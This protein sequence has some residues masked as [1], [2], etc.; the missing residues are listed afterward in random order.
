MLL[1]VYNPCIFHVWF[2]YYCIYMDSETLHLDGFRDSTFRIGVFFRILLHQNRNLMD[3]CE[4]T[5]FFFLFYLL[6][7][8]KICHYVLYS[9]NPW[10]V[11]VFRDGQLAFYIWVCWPH[12]IHLQQLCHIFCHIR[13]NS[14]LPWDWESSHIMC[15]QTLLF[16][17]APY[18]YKIKLQTVDDLSNANVNNVMCVQVSACKNGFPRYQKLLQEERVKW[19]IILER[20]EAN[21]GLPES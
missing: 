6:L 5:I 3:F 12:A 8:V 20:H 13:I 11:A 15:I 10:W 1:F 19:T 17:Q 21:F 4:N 14:F 16:G 18:L 2:Y 9:R 7:F